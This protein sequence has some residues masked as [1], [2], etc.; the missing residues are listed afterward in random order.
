MVE[1]IAKTQESK[2][3]TKVEIDCIVTLANIGKTI[4]AIIYTKDYNDAIAR[5]DFE[6]AMNHIHALQQM[7]MAQAASR[8][9]PELFRL[10]GH[11][12]K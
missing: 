12:K 5:Q 2:L 3:L 1:E 11:K 6:E 9:H 7:I 10:L 4:H 8:A